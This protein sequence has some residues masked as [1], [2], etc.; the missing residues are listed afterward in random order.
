MQPDSQKQ[1]A[2]AAQATPGG[3]RDEACGLWHATHTNTHRE[4]E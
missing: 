4:R 1:V 3:M 2:S